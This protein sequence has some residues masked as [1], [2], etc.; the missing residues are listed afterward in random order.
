LRTKDRCTHSHYTCTDIR[1]YK[2]HF[3]VS[4]SL[5]YT[6][7]DIL[8][9]KVHFPVSSSLHYTCTDILVHKV[10][11][12]VS[13]SLHYTCT[14]IH[15]YKIQFPVNSLLFQMRSAKQCRR[16]RPLSTHLL[17]LLCPPRFN[18]N[19]TGCG[20]PRQRKVRAYGGVKVT[21]AER[22]NPTM[23][24]IFGNQADIP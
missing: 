21:Q 18:T 14:D 5:H 20:A 10:H 4:S 9:H 6:C 16:M 23:C 13:P 7:N 11:F 15:V 24:G 22:R 3:P 8:I 1:V 2:V 19:C 12:P 17:M